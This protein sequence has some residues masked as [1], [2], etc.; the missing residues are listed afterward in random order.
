MSDHSN[1]V[2][3]VLITLDMPALC[4]AAR[5]GGLPITIDEH[6]LD[7]T[8]GS[9]E[10]LRLFARRG[11]KTA[12]DDSFDRHYPAHYP[13]DV[14]QDVFQTGGSARGYFARIWRGT[15]KW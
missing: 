11:V 5:L 8:N 1:D 9:L 12:I 6:P 4:R 10:L 2:V 13:E 7:D 14:D 15:A 3:S